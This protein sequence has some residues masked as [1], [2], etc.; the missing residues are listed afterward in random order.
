MSID[1]AAAILHPPPEAPQRSGFI[2]KSHAGNL[3]NKK[4]VLRWLEINGFNAAY[5]T[6]KDAKQIKGHFDLRNVVG[7]KAVSDGVEAEE[8]I[9]LAILEPYKKDLAQKRITIAFPRHDERAEWLTF[10]CSAIDPEAIEDE[11]FTPFVEDA[12]TERFNVTCA[13]QPGVSSYLPQRLVLMGTRIRECEVLSKRSAP[14]A[15]LSN[16]KSLGAAPPSDKVAWES[17]FHKDD[18]P[19]DESKPNRRASALSATP[20]KS[21]GK[22]K[23]RSTFVGAPPNL[24]SLDTMPDL[25]DPSDGAGATGGA[26]RSSARKSTT[27][28]RR[29]SLINPGEDRHSE[30]PPPTHNGRNALAV[31]E[32]RG[33]NLQALSHGMEEADKKMRRASLTASDAKK[34]DKERRKSAIKHAKVLAD[35]PEDVATS[36]KQH[37]A[38]HILNEMAHALDEAVDVSDDESAGGTGKGKGKAPVS[39]P[40]DSSGEVASKIAAGATG[41]QEVKV[42]VKTI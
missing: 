33:A 19:L 3:F 30:L 29:K 12:L 34:V 36:Q 27:T 28:Y 41:L 10:I 26:D 38:A 22:E 6:D 25:S 23:R 16:R 35:K 37:K 14:K 42:I 24:I 31:L 32:G 8:A 5:Y 17:T 11:I 9:E 20:E 21:G 39:A 13:T 4:S 18:A 40:A 2:R 7:I 1:M 15:H